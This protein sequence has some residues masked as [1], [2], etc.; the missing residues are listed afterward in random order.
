MIGRPFRR[1]KSGRE[2]LPEV[3]ECLK[4]PPKGLVVVGRPSR[5]SLSDRQDLLW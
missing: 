1:S 4:G 5:R 2:V 3:R